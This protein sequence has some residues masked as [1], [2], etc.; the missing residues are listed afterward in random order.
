MVRGA[1]N[2]GWAVERTTVQKGQTDPSPLNGTSLSPSDFLGDGT[3]RMGISPGD[4]LNFVSC[5]DLFG[6]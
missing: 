5:E 6:T 4:P 2:E 1:G 3:S